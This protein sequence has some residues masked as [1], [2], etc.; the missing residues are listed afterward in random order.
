MRIELRTTFMWVSIPLLLMAGACVHKDI[1]DADLAEKVQVIFDWTKAPDATASQMVLYMYSDER[2]VARHWF[3]NSEGGFIKSYPGAHTAVCHNND[4]SYN[5]L[6]RNHE[7]HDGI[8]FYTENTIVLAGQG[9]S[10][11]SIPRA[12]G[13]EN[14]P[15]RS[16]PPMC[17]GA[18]EREILLVPSAEIQTITLYPEELVSHYTVE[19][20]DVKNLNSADLRIDGSISSLAGGYYPG[21]MQST[22]EAVTYTFTVSA[23]FEQNSLISEFITF[24]VPSDGNRQHMVSVYI[25]TKNRSG[26]LY[27]FDVTDQVNNAPDPKHVHIKIYGLE[28]PEIIIPDPPDDPDNKTG[29]SVDIDNWNIQHFNIKI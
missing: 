10:T 27:T 9:I 8:E 17:Y 6:V 22:D 5:L 28:L 21:R 12:P 14:E 24:G 20:I 25:V 7:P 13:T 19:F 1:S 15:L 3:S 23:A 18:N 16:T 4:D 26:N 29:M 2:D 11:R